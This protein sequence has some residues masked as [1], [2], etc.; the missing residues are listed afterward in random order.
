VRAVEK[1]LVDRVAAEFAQKPG[2]FIIGLLTALEIII[3][4]FLALLANRKEFTLFD[5]QNRDKKY[6]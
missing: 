2:L 6:I 5:S 4:S 1:S 3:R